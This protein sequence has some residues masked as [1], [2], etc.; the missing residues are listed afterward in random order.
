MRLPHLWVVVLSAA[1]VTFVLMHVVAYT[2]CNWDREDC[3]GIQPWAIYIFKLESVAA[4]AAFVVEVPCARVFTEERRRRIRNV[5]M[6][7]VEYFGCYH[8]V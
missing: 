1:V 8:D 4:F 3:S 7:V 6:R 2:S 5:P